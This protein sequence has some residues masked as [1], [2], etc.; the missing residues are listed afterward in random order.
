MPVS[1]ETRVHTF[2]HH[3]LTWLCKRLPR[4]TKAKPLF[5]TLHFFMPSPVFGTWREISNFL[6]CC[7]HCVLPGRDFAWGPVS[8][9][10]YHSLMSKAKNRSKISTL[11]LILICLLKYIL[12]CLCEFP[13]LPV[14]KLLRKHRLFPLATCT[15]RVRKNRVG[16]IEFKLF[17]LLQMD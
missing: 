2:P 17:P 10:D 6:W 4:P 3:L 13:N 15:T 1:I 12:L 8:P 9:L 16:Q 14:V 11:S 5:L 7:T